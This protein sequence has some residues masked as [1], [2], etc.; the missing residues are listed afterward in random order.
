VY[1]YPP[2]MDWPW[3]IAEQDHELQNPTSTEKI[4]LL[5]RYMRLGAESRVLDVACGTGGPA[6]LLAAEYGCRIE[7]V[8]IRPAFVERA[9][10]RAAAAGLEGFVRIE[11]GDAAELEPQP[12]AFDAALCLGAAFVWGNI[13][14][15]ASAVRPA[16]RPGGFVAVGEPY[17]RDGHEAEGF[18]GLRETVTRF[19]NAGLA[20]TGLIAA[21]D[22]DWDRYESL[23]WRAIEEW[24]AE[25]DDADVRAVHEQRREN[26]LRGGRRS[27]LGWA[28]FVGRKP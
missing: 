6:V 16:V 23:H 3:E 25:N 10:A 8:E 2:D 20:L 26:H 7:G 18:T 24:L 22:D 27:G 28:M 11:Q 1:A 4:L 5:G 17:W 12:E 19:E 21:S 9:R 13:G 14:D 15:A